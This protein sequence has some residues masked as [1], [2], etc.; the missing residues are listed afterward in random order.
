[1]LAEFLRWFEPSA[2]TPHGFCLLWEPGLIWLHAVSDAA[3]ALAYFSIPIAIMVFVRRRTDMQHRWVAW[4]FAAF[5]LACGTT[6]TLSILTLWQPFYWLEGGVKLVTAVVSLATAVALWPMIPRALA[7]PSPSALSE[8]NVALEGRIA[9]RNVLVSKLEQREIEL[10][11]VMTTLEHRI[12]ERT[13]SLDAAKRR[14]ET[15]L[16]ASGVTVFTQD[17][18]LA[19]T[20]ISKGE[21]GLTTEQF[22]GRTDAEVMPDRP[23]AALHALKRGVLDTGEAARG[24]FD[25][26]G[27]WFQLTA[28]PLPAGAGIICGA[29]DITRSKRDEAR[30]H[31]LLN[32]TTH[33]VGNLLAVSQAMLR[34]TAAGSATVED[35]SERLGERLRALATSQR[36][37]LRP[38]EASGATLDDVVRSQLAAHSDE[39]GSTIRMEGPHVELDT[40]SIMHIGMALHELATNAS[41]YGALSVP[42][43]T[44]EVSWEV[45]GEEAH[46]RW[47]ESGG[48]AVR[49]PQRRGFGR[50]VIEWAVARA[51]QG[52]VL[53][54]FRPQGLVWELRFPLQS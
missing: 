43:G 2:F 15:A 35:L 17:E 37:L 44:V 11:E 52:R 5:I 49:E 39:A 19:Y 42:G 20:Y 12:A 26:G 36:L 24:E 48:P 54:E 50:E 40:S 30:I 51:V 1:M 29:I 4:L 8:A 23:N 32:E 14:F 45:V 25:V 10:T 33:R 7:L 31:F 9:E 18:H 34:Q 41:K 21:L 28:E 47:H 3:I 13:S 6:H 27:Q 46:L 22:I 38:A 16:A 53:L